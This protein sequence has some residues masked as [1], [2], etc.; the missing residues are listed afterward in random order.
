V[1]S[2]SANNENVP[3]SSDLANPGP[4][5][6]HDDVK[7]NGNGMF[8]A[9]SAL[10]DGI[11]HKGVDVVNVGEAHDAGR[12]NHSSQL[13]NRPSAKRSLLARVEIKRAELAAKKEKEQQKQAERVRKNKAAEKA[14]NRLASL[15][16]KSERKEQDKLESV[17]KYRFAEGMLRELA[18]LDD[19]SWPLEV[20]R[21]LAAV[22][23]ADHG[24]VDRMVVR[25]R[26]AEG[27]AET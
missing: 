22:S 11:D 20:R 27:S 25:L 17:A 19:S 3:A 18:A 5:P 8:T 4:K 24:A 14:I 21:V 1:N 12:S 2:D 10:P 26:N 16:Q 13:G 23:D 6:Q 15:G 7:P 9:T